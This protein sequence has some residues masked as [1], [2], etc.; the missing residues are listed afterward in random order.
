MHKNIIDIL[1]IIKNSYYCFRAE[2]FLNLS[3]EYE[4]SINSY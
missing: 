3:T 2:F 1:S 4:L